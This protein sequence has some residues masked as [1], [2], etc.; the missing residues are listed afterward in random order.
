MTTKNELISA[1]A[2]QAGSTKGAAEKFLDALGVVVTTELKR[3]GEITLPGVGKLTVGRREAREGRNL[4]T[5]EKIQIAARNV[6]K[7]KASK[8]LSDAIA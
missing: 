8:P 3:G 5:G 7:F 6:A 4:H 1:V 2:D